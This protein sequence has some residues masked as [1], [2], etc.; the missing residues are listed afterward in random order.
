MNFEDLA[1][2][3]EIWEIDFYESVEPTRSSECR[4][5]DFFLVGRGKNNDI[6]IGIESIHF[7]K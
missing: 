4:I 2:A 3:L 6:C 5:Q 7:H 1:P